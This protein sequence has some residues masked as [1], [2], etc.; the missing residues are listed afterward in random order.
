MKSIN[1]KRTIIVKTIVTEKFKEEMLDTIKASLNRI[2]L[3]LQ[4]MEFQGKR[5]LSGLEKQNVKQ[6]VSL[7]QQLEAE[8]E[9]RF[10]A[11]KRLQNQQQEVSEWQIGDEVIQGTL[12]GYVDLQIGDSIR[13][14]L[15][16]EI[17]VKDGV[18]VE[19]RE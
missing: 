9:K 7:R 15:G 18:V 10:E 4:Q 14:I 11:K 19:I 16:S 17:V 2:E 1:V 6:A 5:T 12:E 8:R 3:E 13:S